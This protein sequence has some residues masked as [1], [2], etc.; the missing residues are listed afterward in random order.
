MV[1]CI[2]HQYTVYYVLCV[3]ALL[4]RAS[5]LVGLCDRIA[6]FDVFNLHC[7]PFYLP[8]PLLV[9]DESCLAAIQVRAFLSHCLPCVSYGL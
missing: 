4:I 8:L 3:L 1:L 5:A 9:S 7:L 2:H 6:L